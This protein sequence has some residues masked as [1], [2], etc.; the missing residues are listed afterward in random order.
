VRIIG[1]RWKRTPLPLP[2]VPGLRPTPDRV[3]ETLFNW[4][5]HLRPDFATLRGLDLFA[6]SGALGFEF[7]SRGA[8]QVTLIERDTRA[9]AALH[10]LRAKLAAD[11]V[12]IVAGDALAVAAQL[13]PAS[14]DLIFLD[15][16]FA[17]ALLPPALAAARRLLTP[18]GLIYAESGGAI[19]PLHWDALAL[20]LIRNDRAGQVFFHLLAPREA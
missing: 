5:A 12:H 9:L 14:F 7:A 16:P 15:P 2:A 11:Q 6:G 13:P 8:A 4:L 3:R 17:T 18:A 19:E 10:A 1:G 20:R